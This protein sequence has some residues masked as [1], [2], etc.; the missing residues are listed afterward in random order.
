M[1]WVRKVRTWLGRLIRDI[2]RKIAGD[3]L[4]EAQFATELERSRKIFEQK[5]TD[6]T[7]ALRP[8]CPGS[9]VHR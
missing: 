2:E 5:K 6:Q 8:A 9:G 7:Q 3:K 1:R 4:T